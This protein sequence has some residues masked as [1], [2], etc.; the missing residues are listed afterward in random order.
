MI[1]LAPLHA[2]WSRALTALVATPPRAPG[3]WAITT[4]L[5][6]RCDLCVT[7]DRFLRAANQQQLEWRLAKERRTHVHGMI[8]S[9]ELPVTHVTRRTGSPFTLVLTK[10]R[11]LLTLDA[12]ERATWAR[13]LAWLHD[14]AK[15]FSSPRPTPA[16]P[17]RR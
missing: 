9:H 11:A 3:D 17:T 10:A 16:R 13:D 8:S 15:A 4:K 5:G 2:D 12:D 7:L 1:C 6:C 14:S